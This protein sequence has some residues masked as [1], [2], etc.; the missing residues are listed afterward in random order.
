MT[1]KAEMA[2]ALLLPA[3]ISI[4]TVL[5]SPGMASEFVVPPCN[6]N[7]FGSAVENCLSDF[8]KSMETSGY[9]E[10]CPWPN[11]RRIYNNLKVCVEKR[12]SKTW[13]TGYK[14]LVDEVFLKVHWRY[15]SLCEEVQDPPFFTLVMLIAPVIIAT[16][17]MPLLCVHLTTWERSGGFY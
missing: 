14:F 8:N 9:Q 7:S 10:K 17:F 5:F 15:F 13:C 1:R 12:A 2:S 16:L 6:E 11:V 3:L 4:W